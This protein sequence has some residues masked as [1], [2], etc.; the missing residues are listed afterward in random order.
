MLVK[1]P[2]Y[3]GTTDKGGR[4]R[5]ERFWRWG[6]DANGRRRSNRQRRVILWRRRRGSSEVGRGGDKSRR[7]DV[8][9]GTEIGQRWRR[10]I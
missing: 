8:R 5:N 4:W 10:N 6:L 3:L 1:V 2:T 7:D 9:D